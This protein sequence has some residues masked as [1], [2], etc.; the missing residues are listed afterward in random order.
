MTRKIRTRWAIGTGL[1]SA[2]V[3]AFAFWRVNLDTHLKLVETQQRDEA[4]QALLNSTEYGY[5]IMDASGQVIEWNQALERLS[6]WSKA[7]IQAK[8]LPAI[9]SPE[10]RERHNNAVANAMQKTE[11]SR[12][13]NVVHCSFPPSEPGEKPVPV[14]ITVRTVQT[15]HGEVFAIAHVDLESRVIESTATSP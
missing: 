4:V 12:P 9:M 7:E 13:I 14:R 6:H 8:G 10:I 5:A 11:E 3:T 2:A 15:S 1:L